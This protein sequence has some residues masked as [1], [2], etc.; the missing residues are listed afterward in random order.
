MS[1]LHYQ[2]TIYSCAEAESVL[3]CLTRQGAVV[4]S[5]CCSGV[6]QTCLMRATKGT[7]PSVA[8][9]GLKPT[10]REQGYFLACQCRPTEDM[11][12]ALAGEEVAPRTSATVVEKERLNGDI[13]R[14]SLRCHKPLDY[15]AGQ[16]AHII[17][18]D[19][20]VR[21]YSLTAPPG[22]EGLIE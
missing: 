9:S 10:L 8:Q 11:E 16:F 19:G 3:D 13:L 15:R 14:L 12:V 7:P 20:L 6:C 18:S 5:S 4:P 1:L 2:E 21:S 17:R 22:E